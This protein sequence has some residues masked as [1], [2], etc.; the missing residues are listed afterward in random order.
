VDLTHYACWLA[1][2]EPLRWLGEVKERILEPFESI[3]EA[4][5]QAGNDGL[6]CQHAE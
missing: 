4:R 1:E 5:L 3:I 2:C 6:S